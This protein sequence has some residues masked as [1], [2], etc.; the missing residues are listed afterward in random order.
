MKFKNLFADRSFLWVVCLLLIA[1]FL[2]FLVLFF[3]KEKYQQKKTKKADDHDWMDILEKFCNNN[4]GEEWGV[5]HIFRYNDNIMFAVIQVQ[6]AVVDLSIQ[7]EN[8][9][10][11]IENIKGKT[12]RLIKRVH[13]F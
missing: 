7:P 12:S 2:L 8:R 3:Q 4:F 5:D 6:G 13:R 10:I 11:I 1:S 9:A